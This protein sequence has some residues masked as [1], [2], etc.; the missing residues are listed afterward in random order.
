M[1]DD[2]TEPTITSR[3][4][5]D[6]NRAMTARPVP[7]ADDRERPLTDWDTG[8]V[9]AIR[10]H[11]ECCGTLRNHRA[12]VS[13]ST[14]DAETHRPEWLDDVPTGWCACGKPWPHA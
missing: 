7:A 11:D 3:L 6:A 13:P 8:Y 12:G 4:V 5:Q 1:K 2:A 9:T 14:G 10:D